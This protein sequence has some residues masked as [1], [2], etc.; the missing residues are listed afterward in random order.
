MN[1]NKENNK[2]KI[3]N[4]INLKYILIPS[5]VFLLIDTIIIHKRVGLL[6]LHIPIIS[7][8]LNLIYDLLSKLIYNKFHSQTLAHTIIF[9]ILLYIIFWITG[10][11]NINILNKYNIPL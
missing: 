11:F 1:N 5:L 4:S 3:K 2:Q 9:S 8:I 6:D 7:N 10:N